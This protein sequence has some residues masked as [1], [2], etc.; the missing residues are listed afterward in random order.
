MENFDCDCCGGEIRPN[1]NVNTTDDGNSFLCDWCF[2]DV[3]ER[4]GIK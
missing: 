4:E 1:E 3:L 2:N